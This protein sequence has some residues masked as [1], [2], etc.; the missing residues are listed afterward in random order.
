MLAPFIVIL[1]LIAALFVLA[2]LPWLLGKSRK[3]AKQA[4]EAGAQ[5][6]GLVRARMVARDADAAA[7]SEAARLRRAL[8]LLYDDEL[9][10]FET[11]AG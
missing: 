8:A 7:A 6:A 9:V 10:S 4:A 1:F 5:A 11:T 2:Y 3:K